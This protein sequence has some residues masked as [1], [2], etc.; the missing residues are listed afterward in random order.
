MTVRGAQKPLDLEREAERVLS[1]H[2]QAGGSHASAI[3]ELRCNGTY[4]GTDIH[5]QMAQMIERGQIIVTL[6]EPTPEFEALIAKLSERFE[7]DPMD[8]LDPKP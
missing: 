1:R 4:I 7:A 3:H 6:P 8:L 2:L 5:Y